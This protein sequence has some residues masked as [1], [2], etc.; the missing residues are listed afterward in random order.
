[1]KPIITEGNHHSHHLGA[2][3]TAFKYVMINAVSLFIRVN[4][5]CSVATKVETKTDYMKELLYVE[6]H[7][8]DLFSHQIPLLFLPASAHLNILFSTFQ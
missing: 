5:S 6:Q 1:M 3:A 8:A 7:A 4:G 2:I